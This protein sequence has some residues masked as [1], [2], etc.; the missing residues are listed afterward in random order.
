MESLHAGHIWQHS[1]NALFMDNNCGKMVYETDNEREKKISLSGT[2]TF[3]F[4]TAA[5]LDIV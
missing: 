3:S 4:H 2:V 1:K 5:A